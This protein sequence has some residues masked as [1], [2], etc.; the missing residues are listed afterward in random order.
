MD[1][2]SLVLRVATYN[3]RNIC[4]NKKNFLKQIFINVRFSI[5]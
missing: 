1:S 2:S 4:G 3:I 5:T